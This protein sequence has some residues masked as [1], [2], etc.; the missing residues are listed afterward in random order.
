MAKN[1]I[2]NRRAYFDYQIIEEIEAGI[3]LTGEEVK[4]IRSGKANL[5]QAYGKIVGGEMYLVNANIVSE[6]ATRSRKLLLHR[7]EILAIETKIKAKKLTII[8][9][10]V[11]NRGPRF[12]VK[13]GLGKSKKKTEKRELI[14]KREV[15]RE[16]EREYKN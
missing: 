1:K 16:I 14:K 11:Y 9:L 5:T 10:E 6:N 7:A 3:V 4:A 12:K 8:P 13:L 2:V 15:E